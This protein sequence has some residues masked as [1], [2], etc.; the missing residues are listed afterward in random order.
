MINVKQVRTKVKQIK[1]CMKRL[2]KE[3]DML[4]LLYG[5]VEELLFDLDDAE[6]TVANSLREIEHAVDSI[7]RTI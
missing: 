5:D 6:T 1:A 7:S 2:S 3:R 4:R